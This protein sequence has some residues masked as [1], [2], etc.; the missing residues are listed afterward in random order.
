M[1]VP[2]SKIYAVGLKTEF[3][4]TLKLLQGYGKLHITNLREDIDSGALPIEPM[5]FFE[6]SDAQMEELAALSQR[7]SALVVHL[8]GNSHAL[9]NTCSINGMGDLEL[10]EMITVTSELL[11]QI[12]PQATELLLGVVSAEEEYAELQQYEPLLTKVEPTV[13]QLVGG[14]DVFSMAVLI[15][16]RYAEAISELQKYLKE[17]TEGTA[18]VVTK[19]L[20]D[21]MMAVIII[22]ENVYVGQLREL[23]SREEFNQIKL[24]DNFNEMP[25]GEALAAMRLRI[26]ELADVIENAKCAV[27]FFAEE[28][29][30][31]LCEATNEVNNRISQ[32][33]AI[34]CF[35]ET[36]YAFVMAGYLPTAEVPAMRELF[37]K[38]LHGAACI[39][40]KKIEPREFAEVPVQL[41]NKKALKPFQAALGVWGRPMYG[42]FDPTWVLALSFPFI[43]GMIVG[44]FGYGSLILIISLFV[45]WKY[46][47]KPA[48]QIA[49]GLFA[50]VGIMTMLFG[51]FYFEL[52]GDLAIKYIPGLNQ[53]QPIQIVGD[54]TI[55]LIRTHGG[56]RNIF[57]FA[58]IGF[59]LIQV[60]IGL[61]M[62]IVNAKRGGHKKH[63]LEKA[64]ILTILFSA[65]LLAVVSLVPTLTAGMAE[66]AGAIVNYLIYL[67]LAIGVVVTIAGG[68]IMGAIETIES[69]AHVASYIRIMAVGLVGALL[70]DAS[71]K[72]MF[73]TM[74]NAAGVIIGLILHTLN[75]AII[76][77]SP[78]IHALRLNF[79]EFFGKFW[80]AGRVSYKPFVRAGKAG[81]S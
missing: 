7:G 74:P 43:F 30:E 39:E 13:E 64:G 40:E 51:L 65:V 44:D 75:F 14:Q 71:N 31:A 12:E 69:V 67:A 42:T 1:L 46:P 47:D 60:I 25:F 68:G 58:A 56:A 52:F 3:F 80:E 5:N 16:S 73:E 9:D 21:G 37:E 53:I 10:P 57:L 63:I 18:N 35:G 79:L 34:D 32:L 76:L 62:G 36:K 38:E 15:E 55:P 6:R 61:I 45:L 72:L 24:P 8:F 41:D 23:I 27:A 54:F 29:R 59:G 66:P 22:V 11:D 2:M 49:G 50:P 28:K 17:I 19:T 33:E 81:K 70:A 77:F 48:A 26:G 4:P 78:S 20:D